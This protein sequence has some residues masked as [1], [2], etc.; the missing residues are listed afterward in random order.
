MKKVCV[1]TTFDSADPSYSL[2][3]VCEDQLKMLLLGGYKPVVI[4][5][6]GFTPVGV[7]ADERV[8]IEKAKK[9]TSSNQGILPT[10]WKDEVVVL[11]KQYKE[12]FEKHKVDVVI[13]HDLIA[14][15][16]A[17]VNNMAGREVA[18][19]MPEISWRHFIHSVFSSNVESN[20]LE[21]SRAGREKWPTKFKLVFP[22]SY[23]KSRVARN[24]HVE[25][26]D[27][28]H[29]PHP[30]DVLALFDFEPELRKI[31]EDNHVLDKEVVMVLPARLDRGKQV[32]M[33]VE[34]AAAI[35]RQGTSVAFI[36]V[37][38]SSTGGDKVTYRREMRELA[39]EKGL[40]ETDVIFLSE[41]SEKYRY[42]GTKKTVGNLFS[43]SNIFMLA[44]KSETYSLVTQEAGLAGNF[45][46]LNWDFLPTRSVFG[47]T[48]KYFKFSS[49]IDI[50]SGMDGSSDT[51]YGDRDAYFDDIG[52]YVRHMIKY[53]PV[54]SMKTKLRTTRS[55]QAVWR[56]YFEPMLYS[57]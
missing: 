15:P 36:C 24:F 29:V 37:D 31:I 8:I 40:D 55:L 28:I 53:D 9:A 35:K 16:A 48:P 5:N 10:T 57:D 49:N 46:I 1:L 13:T 7:Y 33:N 6:D 2:N 14:Q 50:L 43:I 41:Q 26:L 23:D 45:L 11:A 19:E 44:S 52:R 4:V 32:H 21:V 34:A 17:L 20:I 3:L 38:F 18:K 39:A 25:E 56:N 42:S 30:S 47:D 54:L 22:N 51:N 27:V 12:I